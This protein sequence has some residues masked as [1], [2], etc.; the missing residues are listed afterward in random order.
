M[1]FTVVV[2]LERLVLV[3]LRFHERVATFELVVLREPE[4]LERVLLVVVRL[5]VRMLR[6]PERD[7]IVLVF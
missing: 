6:F 7:E 4:R 5:V 2:R 1:E 3:V